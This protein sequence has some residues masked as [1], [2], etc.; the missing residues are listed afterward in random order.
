MLVSEHAARALTYLLES[1][2]RSAHVVAEAI[3]ALLERASNVLDDR[4][5]AVAEQSLT[6]LEKLSPRHARQILQAKGASMVVCFLD[7][8]T[9]VSQ[10]KVT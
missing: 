1:L 4:L 6:C 10:R 9:L 2:P 7:F 3:P 8:F 5:M